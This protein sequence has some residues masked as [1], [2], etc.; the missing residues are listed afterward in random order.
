MQ[1]II[2]KEARC[3]NVQLL[4]L[5]EETM[6]KGVDKRAWLCYNTQALRVCMN[7]AE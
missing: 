6:R 7:I 5:T 4:D 2:E 1:F 3:V